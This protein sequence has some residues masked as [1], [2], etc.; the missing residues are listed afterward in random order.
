MRSC[1][2]FT[3]R[4][5]AKFAKAPRRADNLHRP[6]NIEPDRLRDVFCFR[7]E[8]SLARSWHS[9]MNV[10]G[11][12]WLRM[13]SRAG[14][15]ANMSIPMPSRMGDLRSAG[16]VSRSP[17]PSSTRISASPTPRSPRTNISARFWS[18]SKP[19]RTSRS[20]KTPRRQTGD[21][22]STYRQT[23]RWLELKAGTRAKEKAET[24]ASLAAE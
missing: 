15:R 19:S 17:T 10:S 5:N 13:R 23:Q 3:E 22:L 18:T 21:T 4:Y 20:Q 1:P 16:R 14:C 11:S 7:D 12:S 8:R 6:M 2:D 24:P 9:P